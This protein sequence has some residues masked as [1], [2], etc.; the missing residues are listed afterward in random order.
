MKIKIRAYRKKK[1]AT[2]IAQKVENQK[3][4]I[5]KFVYYVIIFLLIWFVI[6]YLLG[7]IMPFIFGYM[8]AALVQPAAYVLRKR[9]KINRKAA[10]I[11]TVFMFIL[12]FGG[13]LLLLITKAV[14][15]FVAVSSMIPSVFEQLSMAISH[16]SLNIAQYIDTLPVAFSKQVE[17]SLLS[18][19]AE[20]LKLSSISS[21]VVSFAMNIVSSVPG[22]LFEIII[23][24]VS[25][26]FISMDYGTI[27][28]FVL[29]QLPTKYQPWVCDIK[30]FFFITI[31]KLI[32]AYFTLMI[33]TFVELCIGLTLLRVPHSIAVAAIIALV[34][35]LPV[36]GTGSVLIPWII[37][38]ILMGNA[39]LAVGLLIV[40]AIIVVVRNIFEPKIVGHHIGLYPLVTLV[41]M[42]IGLKMLGVGGMFLFPIVVIIVKHMQ[43][44]GKIKLWKD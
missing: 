34:D 25:A 17:N 26:C 30:E 31:A 7:L 23:T 21:G 27:R 44:T 9:L 4:F 11:I 13:L 35:I 6:K 39:F 19:S 33:I 15:E 32:R 28:G 41:S 16:L 14:S 2:M 24:I 42:F 43:D 18:V 10:G 12:I 36:L 8:I 37:I 38:E 29:R 40:F 3:F 20:L 1:G 5:V 22:L